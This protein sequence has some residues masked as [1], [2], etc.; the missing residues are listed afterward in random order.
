MK[1]QHLKPVVIGAFVAFLVG[2]GGSNNATPSDPTAATASTSVEPQFERINGI[3]VPPE[4][5]RSENSRTV[6]GVDLDKNGVRDDMDRWAAKKFGHVPAV[7]HPIFMT[8][9]ANQ[10][11]LTSNPVTNNDAIAMMQDSIYYGVC[12]SEV[13]ERNG[14]DF[15]SIADEIALR[16]VNTRE[17]INKT[18]AIRELAGAFLT[19]AGVAH[20]DCPHP[21]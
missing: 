6:E 14:F 8:M 21:Q 5:S 19:T 3:L 1:N 12:G 20:K 17:R 13:I 16:T 15:G 2:C 4:P 18:K 9:R 11:R 7:V 10:M